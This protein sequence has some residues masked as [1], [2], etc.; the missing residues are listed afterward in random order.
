MPDV[1]EK[2]LDILKSTGLTLESDYYKEGD[3]LSVNLSKGGSTKIKLIIQNS[4]VPE[5]DIEINEL[6]WY[7]SLANEG[8]L[9]K[10]ISEL[11]EDILHLS[12]NGIAL[13]AKKI[14]LTN[15]WC[16]VDP[17][18]LS[19]LKAARMGKFL[20]GKAKPISLES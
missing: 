14:F 7:L 11:K 13:T 4:D 8:E 3:S 18:D 2:C 6:K 17:S 20:P 10:E 15:S 9:V 16:L 12:K 5:V 19:V 1:Y